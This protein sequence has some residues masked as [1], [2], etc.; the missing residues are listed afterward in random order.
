MSLLHNLVFAICFYTVF[1]GRVVGWC[2]NDTRAPA[3]I[4]NSPLFAGFKH[5][6][7]LLQN[8]YSQ[9]TWCRMFLKSGYLPVKIPVSLGYCVYC[10]MF[11]SVLIHNILTLP[12]SSISYQ[13]VNLASLH[14]TQRVCLCMC[15]WFEIHLTHNVEFSSV[16]I[17][18]V[19]P[20]VCPV[21]P[22]VDA[23]LL[24]V[25]V[26]WFACPPVGVEEISP[27]PHPRPFALLH[28]VVTTCPHVI[29]APLHY[30]NK[31]KFTHS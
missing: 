21:G 31:D 12:D 5:W 4:I 19:P 6:V 28:H 17:P 16:T 23:V 11:F 1:C 9:F 26:V 30:S 7:L 15:L 25:V 18:V 3:H 22:H 10:S 20:V 8:N 27:C 14:V 24:V 2:L 29:A 13:E